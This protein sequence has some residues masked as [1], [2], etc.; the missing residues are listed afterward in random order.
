MDK[1]ILEM[2]MSKLISNL[3]QVGLKKKYFCIALFFQWTSNDSVI[4][5]HCHKHG[6]EKEVKAEV[7]QDFSPTTPS[8]NRPPN[9]VLLAARKPTV[10]AYYWNRE[11]NFTRMDYPNSP[12]AICSDP[13]PLWYA[14]VLPQ[15]DKEDNINSEKLLFTSV[16]IYRNNETHETKCCMMLF[17]IWALWCIIT[18][19]E[20]WKKSSCKWGIS[21]IFLPCGF[22]GT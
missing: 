2:S 17:H 1:A 13:L 18:T 16:L 11:N 20:F 4:N 15:L 6:P 22:F 8:C 19:S 5:G 7:S 21:N 12:F 14:F 3:F 9:P 10:C